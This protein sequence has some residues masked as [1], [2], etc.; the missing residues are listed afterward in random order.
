MVLPAKQLYLALLRLHRKT[1][2]P[3]STTPMLLTGKPYLY[4]N[5]PTW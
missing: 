3:H 4:T 2:S 1:A 5:S